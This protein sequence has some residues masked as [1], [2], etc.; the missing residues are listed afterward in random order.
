MTSGGRVLAVSSLG[1]D[2][3]DALATSYKNA[4]K[5]AFRDIYYRNDIGFDL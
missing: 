5:I 4:G 1:E 3:K 2:M